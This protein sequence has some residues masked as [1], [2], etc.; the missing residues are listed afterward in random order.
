MNGGTGILPA[1]FC[2]RN[3]RIGREH[4]FRR[5]NPWR[6]WR[7]Y[8]ALRK[9]HHMAG[10]E[11]RP[12]GFRRPR[13]S[14]PGSVKWERRTAVLHKFVPFPPAHRA[15]LLARVSPAEILFI[16]AR[17]IFTFISAEPTALPDIPG[18]HRLPN[19]SSAAATVS[20]MSASLCADDTKPASKGDGAK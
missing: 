1:S 13:K 19:T 6:T 9:I 3:A 12:Y 17:A 5:A 20:A 14:P 8:L 16:E 7:A 2:R 15:R 18:H 11:E 10:Q 4:R